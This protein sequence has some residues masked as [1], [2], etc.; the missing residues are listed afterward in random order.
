MF[1]MCMK[2]VIQVLDTEERHYHFKVSNFQSV[3]RVY[4][5]R[6]SLPM[7][8]VPGWNRVSYSLFCV[9]FKYFNSNQK[10]QMHL[11]VCLEV[12]VK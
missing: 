3:V 4:G 7:R 10:V 12:L 1:N 5:N 2:L 9:P 11:V 6:C 8:L